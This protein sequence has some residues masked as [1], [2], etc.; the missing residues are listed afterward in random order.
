MRVRI[1]HNGDLRE[2]TQQP[3]PHW[4][5]IVHEDGKVI[6][7]V[8]MRQW[9]QFLPKEFQVSDHGRFFDIPPELT[10]QQHLTSAH[11]NDLIVSLE[12]RDGHRDCVFLMSQLPEGCRLHA[13]LSE[14]L[15]KIQAMVEA[16][17]F[18]KR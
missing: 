5:V 3:S 12:R 15:Q 16:V 4:T 10:A 8:L 2:E 14:L 13:A 17:P 1:L 6:G 18:E 9:G 7:E 11:C